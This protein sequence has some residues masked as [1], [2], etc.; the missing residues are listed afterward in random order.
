MLD[1]ECSRP[2]QLDVPNAIR[3]PICHRGCD[4][5]GAVDAAQV[6]VGEVKRKRGLKILPL[7]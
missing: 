4:P 7:L 3:N 6:V 1:R 5:Q 2:V